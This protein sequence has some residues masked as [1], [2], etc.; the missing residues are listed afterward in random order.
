MRDGCAVYHG[1]DGHGEVHPHSVDI[2]KAKETKENNEMTDSK[3]YC[4]KRREE[5]I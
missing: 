5:G 4:R 2:G 1:H 3:G